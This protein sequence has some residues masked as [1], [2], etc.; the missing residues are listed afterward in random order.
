MAARVDETKIFLS[1]KFFLHFK[2]TK[3]I[4]KFTELINTFGGQVEQFLEQTVSYVLTDIPKNEWPPQCRDTIL[5][6]ALKLGVKLMSINDLMLWCRKYAVSSDDDDEI[7]KGTIKLIEAPFLKFEDVSGLYAPSYKQFGQWPELNVTQQNQ[8]QQFQQQQFQQQ[9][10]QQQQQQ[11]FQQFPQQPQQQQLQKQQQT[12][13]Q[14]RGAKKRH[15]VYCEI[16]SV[17]INDEIEDHIKTEAH[18]INTNKVDWTEVN[19]VIYS[20]PGLSTLNMKRLSTLSP[21]E[22]QEF[23]CLHKFE[24]ITQL[25][26]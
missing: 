10:L 14:H 20:L 25:F 15:S 18:K 1:K 9:Q 5:E 8:Q 2:K 7:A 11:Q 17:K 4:P 24:S 13:Q 22:P 23:V 12:P 3:H 16:C 6:G 26:N 19:N 21:M